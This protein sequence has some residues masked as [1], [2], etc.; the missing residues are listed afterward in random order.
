MV[1]CGDLE[2]WDGGVGG[3]LESEGMYVYTQ[4]IHLVV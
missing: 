2:G 3:R 4:L 1:L